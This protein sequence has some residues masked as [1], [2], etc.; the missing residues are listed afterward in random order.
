MKVSTL[1]T[2]V[3]LASISSAAVIKSEA[4]VQKRATP[5]QTKQEWIK[6]AN[7]HKDSKR[8]TF[9]NTLGAP[10]WAKIAELETK[11]KANPK[12]DKVK[13]MLVNAAWQIA[14]G[15]TPDFKPSSGSATNKTVGKRANMTP[16]Q[17]KQKWI[18][19][20]NDHKD[21]K[22]VAFLNTLGAPVW[23]KIA[24][25]ET[26][27]A[28]NP[29]DDK[30][31]G[32]LVNAAWQIASGKTPDFKPSSGSAT[33]KTVGKRANMTPEQ[34]K[35]KWIK[36][37]NDHKDS[38]RVAFLNTLGAPVWTK[39][40]ELETKQ[41]ANPNDDK[42]KG[43]LVNAAWQIASGK[44]PDF[45]PSTGGRGPQNGPAPKLNHRSFPV[46]GK[47][48]AEQVKQEHLRLAGLMKNEK[49]TQFLNGLQLPVWTK[50]ADLVNKQRANP[51]DAAAKKAI[52]QVEEQ[53]AKMQKPTV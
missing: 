46:T 53:I 40:A 36:E 37:A 24:E 43:M 17:A 6:E 27:Q 10:V 51:K 21:S 42:V 45:K 28:A 29:K 15:K 25:L 47:V 41:A 12:D 1:L 44:T 39:I 13:G 20:A 30:V 3:L 8:V 4:M 33:N 35:Q 50:V 22:R 26:K 18:K 48:T 23:T 38:K 32:M 19:E 7:D 2:T 49:L 52:D 16:E 9:L 11:Q 31:K 14:S 34:A 5:E